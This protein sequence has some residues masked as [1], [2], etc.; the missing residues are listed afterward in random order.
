MQYVEAFEVLFQSTID[1]L[2]ATFKPSKSGHIVA[3]LVEASIVQVNEYV[4]VG[5][6]VVQSGEHVPR[7]VVH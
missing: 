7:E 5:D 6:H 1:H 4:I 2:V 3:R